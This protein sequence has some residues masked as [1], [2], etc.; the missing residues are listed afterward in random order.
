MIELTVVNSEIFQNTPNIECCICFDIM[1]P[2][3][4]QSLWKCSVCKNQLSKTKPYPW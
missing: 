4:I 3:N 2:K 1:C